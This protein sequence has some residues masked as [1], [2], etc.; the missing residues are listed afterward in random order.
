MPDPFTAV[1]TAAAVADLAKLVKE[2]ILKFNEC[3]EAWNELPGVFA[4]LFDQLQSLLNILNDCKHS[5]EQNK[6][7]DRDTGH[8]LNAVI[9]SCH[10]NVE[11]LQSLLVPL[12]AASADGTVKKGWK[13]A[14]SVWKESEVCKV[15]SKMDVHMYRIMFYCT[16]SASTLNPN[17]SKSTF[18]KA[19][20]MI[21]DQVQ[22]SFSTSLQ[23]G[24][25]QPTNL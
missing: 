19:L 9:N 22:T 14:K 18:S 5:I 16:W 23:N 12:I 2:I 1:A 4:S 8:A 10:E 25:R 15:E 11:K 21:A 13:K 20:H 17:N 7:S 24:W 3:R 6:I